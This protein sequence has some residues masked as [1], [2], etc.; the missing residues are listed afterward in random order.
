MNDLF[1]C[2]R[3]GRASEITREMFLN[4]SI[5]HLG[6]KESDFD[7]SDIDTPLGSTNRLLSETWPNISYLRKYWERTYGFTSVVYTDDENQLLCGKY[8]NE[9]GVV[10]ND[11]LYIYTGGSVKAEN[12]I[13][14]FHKQQFYVRLPSEL[15][16]Y[17]DEPTEEIEE[18]LLNSYCQLGRKEVYQRSEFM[19][20]LANYLYG[21]VIHRILVEDDENLDR[22][23]R[24]LSEALGGAHPTYVAAIIQ[25]ALNVLN[26]RGN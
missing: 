19:T 2:L 7:Y 24:A 3:E 6:E 14:L 21:D 16:E 9:N 4:S 8:V 22:N 13:K 15:I 17:G 23:F 18:I 25:K 20:E 26:P 11:T 5:Y 12:Q 1:T 10:Y